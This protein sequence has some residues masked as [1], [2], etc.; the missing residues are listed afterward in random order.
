MEREI[1]LLGD[2]RLYEVCE[3]VKQEELE[4]LRPVFEDLFDSIMA[5]RRDY[6][7][8]RAIAAPQIGVMKR[9]ICMLTDRPY[10]IINPELEFVGDEMME[11]MDDCMSLKAPVFWAITPGPS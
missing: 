6:G 1:L 8:G 2:P 11:L 7:F 10:V 5:I 9:V 4:E 3:P